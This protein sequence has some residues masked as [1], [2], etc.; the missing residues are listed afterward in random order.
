M[1][2]G[3]VTLWNTQ[4]NYGGVLQ[5]Y[6]LQKYLSIQGHSPFLVR[7][8][9][10]SVILLFKSFIKKILG[11]K[12]Y[13]QN[14]VVEYEQRCFDDFRKDHTS[15]TKQ[16]FNSVKQLNHNF[17]EA[18]VFIAGS[19]QVWNY[20][21]FDGSGDPYFLDFGH[22]RK[23]A[24][25]AYAVSFGSIKVRPKFL[26]YIS[27]R[28]KKFDAISCREY[29]GVDICK[30][31]G[32]DLDD[33]KTV[34]DP[35][36][37]LTKDNY[38]QVVDNHYDVSGNYIMTYFL[39]WKTD[40]PKNEIISFAKKYDFQLRYVPSQGM[41][42]TFFGV[43]PDYPTIPQWISLVRGAKHLVTN[44]FHGTVFAIIYHIPFIVIPVG[45]SKERMNSRITTLLKKIGCEERIYKDGNLEENLKK[46]INWNK[47]DACLQSWRDE[48]SRW[49]SNAINK[50]AL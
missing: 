27:P 18:D 22:N 23:F 13:V 30:M 44:S 34:C 47:V 24:R 26:K 48:S 21:T 3:I 40:I 39:G 15:F 16:E 49:L 41:D 4:T 42:Y 29:E 14:K 50:V 12:D 35:T 31:A 10:R 11:K 17:P 38:N 20:N 28:L 37:L 25:I 46:N 2:I 33:L 36:I 43:T 19:D 8:K 1:K 45:R 32:I 5:N 7:Y 9:H 6:A